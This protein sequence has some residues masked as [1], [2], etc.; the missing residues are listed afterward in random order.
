M[1]I[2]HRVVNNADSAV[3]VEDLVVRRGGRVALD[4]LSL[5]VPRGQVLG[6]LGPSGSGKSTLIRAIVGVQ[7][8]ESGRVEVLGEPAGSRGLRHRVGYVTQAPSVYDDLTVRANL[9][10]FAAVCGADEAGV[11]KAI[12]VVDLADHADVLVRNLSGGQRARANLAVALVG[13]PDLLVL[14]EPTVELDPVLRRSLWD[15]F[16]RLADAGASLLVSSHVMDEARRCDRLVLLRR[17]RVLADA[18]YSELLAQ[19]GTDDAESAFLSLIDGADACDA[20]SRPTGGAS[21]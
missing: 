3:V 1:T 15:L 12:D 13:T 11:G 18:T 2:I 21:A 17:G 10:Y 7:I 5:N 6:V 19:T 9:A 4:G 20:P 14:D 16:H 8:V